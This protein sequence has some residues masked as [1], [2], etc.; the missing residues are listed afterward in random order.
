MAAPEINSLPR[1]KLP[2]FDIT[3]RN[4]ED[5]HYEAP[6]DYNQVSRQLTPVLASNDALLKAFGAFVLAVSDLEDA[7]FTAHV[8]SERLLVTAK[9]PGINEQL[10]SFSSDNIA[11]SSSPLTAPIADGLLDF[12]IQIIGPESASKVPKQLSSTF[13]LAVCPTE[14]V[15]VADLQLF[16][17]VR[18]GHAQSTTHL[19]ELAARYLAPEPSADPSVNRAE[20]FSCRQN[21]PPTMISRPPLL[22]SDLALYASEADCPALFHSAFERRAAESPDSS[23]IEYIADASGSIEKWTYGEVHALAEDLMKELHILETK[24]VW[25]KPFNGQRIVPLYLPGCPQLYAGY[26]G[27]MKAGGAFCPLPLDAPP[28]R[29]QVILEDIEAPVVLGLGANP[30]PGLAI[31]AAE[32]HI[33]EF[34]RNIVW[35]DMA[36]LSAWRADRPVESLAPAQPRTPKEE[37]LAYILYTS[38]STGK[39]KG[40]LIS[41]ISA[42]CAIG[43]HDEAFPHLAVG[44]ALRWLQFAMPTFDLSLIEIFVT[45]GNAGTLCVAERTL[46]LTDIERTIKLFQANTI[47]TVPSL[48]TLLRPAKVPSLTTLVVGGE[49]LNKYTIDNFSHDSLRGP[50]EPQRHLI[51]IYGPT[52]ATMAV[53]TEE[54]AVTTRG[55]VIGDC[56]RCAGIVIVDPNSD[57]LVETPSPLTGELAIIGPQVGFGYLN[58]PK[59][60]NAAFKDGSKLGLGPVYKTGDRSRIVWAAD[61]R[62]K[63]EIL[64]R[65]S[66]EQVKLNGR[67]VELSEIESGVARSERVREVATVVLGKA[68]LVAYIS[69]AEATDSP[70]ARELAIADCRDVADRTMPTWMRPSDYTVLAELPRTA[71]GKVDRK[72]L[73][74]WAQEALGASAPV[75]A[76]A[77]AAK[78]T[79]DFTSEDSVRELI[80]ATIASVIGDAATSADATVPLYTWGI[81]SLQGMRVLQALREYEVEGLTLND[82]M[83]GNSLDALAKRIVALQAAAAQDSAAAEIDDGPIEIEDEEELLFLPLV[84]KLKHFEAQCLPQCVAGLGVPAEEIAHVLPATGMQTRMV[85]FFQECVDELGLTK[86]Y[87]EHFPYKVP[88]TFDLDRFEA[89]VLAVLGEHDAFRTV[90]CPVEHPLTPFAQVVL[91]RDSPRAALPVVRIICSAHDERPDSLWTKTIEQAQKSAYEV[92]SLDQPGAVVTFVYDEAREHCV[93]IWS[94]FHMIYDGVSLEVLRREIARAYADPASVAGI[95][96]KCPQGVRLPIEAHYS[97]DWLE[98]SLYWMRERA[99]A[100]WFKFGDRA[101]PAPGE[102]PESFRNG[103]VACETLLSSL[104]LDDLNEMTRRHGL[105]SALAVAQAAYSMALAQTVAKLDASGSLS[106]DVEVQFG[107]VIHG[108]QTPASL[109]CVA[110]MLE[111]LPAYINYKAAAAPRM[112]HRDAVRH[113]LAEHVEQMPHAQMPC[114][115]V[116]FAKTGRRLDSSIILQAYPKPPPTS[117]SGAAAVDDLPGFNREENLLPPWQETFTG[118]PLLMELWQGFD[119]PDEQLRIR[120]SYVPTWP[121]YEF[122]SKDWARGLNAALEASL[123]RILNDPD[124]EFDLA[125][126][127]VKAEPDVGDGPSAAEPMDVSA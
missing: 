113:M 69:L 19:L 3:F 49:L 127:L 93:M 56:L 96:T 71:S 55:S 53:A 41:H 1:T 89:A 38:G 47:F 90:T 103:D 112:T 63:V 94:L 13:V 67:R 65:L 28:E 61:G 29:V 11:I 18:N 48:A 42:C 21:G 8:G 126:L 97:G 76:A 70:E 17:D 59:E 124:A 33:A 74:K 66:M 39:P 84:A 87:I 99:G 91:T 68:Q 109:D 44:P 107:T 73:Q 85:A 77:E 54:S 9:A 64:G 88:P 37:D 80:V 101:L 23:C 60:T 12:E 78:M 57:E 119:R 125:A 46:M 118:Y 36:N 4:L 15:N 27:I 115:T 102:F 75:P 35:V 45:L 105:H 20:P 79:V 72:V 32:P 83:V 25:H 98:T 117:P 5:G 26:M 100:G 62:P 50:G 10:R 92:L 81:D 122:M 106:E 110:L 108:R 86:P 51:N 43:G 116:D 22:K 16:V 114:T 95:A 82:I 120:C 31:D 121:G 6:S 52:E 24:V 104:S 34:L 111:T 123:V 7:A 58:R 30:F 14:K 40:V 2:F